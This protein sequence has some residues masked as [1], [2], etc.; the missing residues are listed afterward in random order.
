MIKRQPL[1]GYLRMHFSEGRTDGDDG[2]S[3]G[4]NSKK[5]IKYEIIKYKLNRKKGNIPSQVK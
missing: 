4:K 2:Q 1:Y 5:G 3:G